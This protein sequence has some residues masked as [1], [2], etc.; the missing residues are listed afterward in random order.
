MVSNFRA[1]G[2][3]LGTRKL[4]R[5]PTLIIIIIKKIFFLERAVISILLLQHVKYT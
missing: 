2:I 4:T 5:T 3:N 1:C